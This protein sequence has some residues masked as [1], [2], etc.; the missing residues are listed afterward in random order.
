MASIR[1]FK[2]HINNVLGGV[3]D[4]VYIWEEKHPKEDHKQS[5]KI[6]DD[7]IANFDELITKLNDKSV[8]NRGKHLQEIRASLDKKETELMERINNL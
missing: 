3:I 6:I 4:S 7:A 5:E 8:D 2:K 1:E